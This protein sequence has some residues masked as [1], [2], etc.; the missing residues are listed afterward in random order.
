MRI[1]SSQGGRDTVCVRPPHVTPLQMSIETR[2]RAMPNLQQ[3]DLNGLGNIFSVDRRGFD[4]E[5][6]VSLRM[7]K[8]FRRDN[9]SGCARVARGM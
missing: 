8:E 2:R 1:Q 6:R 9:N 3:F 7:K 5:N 4:N